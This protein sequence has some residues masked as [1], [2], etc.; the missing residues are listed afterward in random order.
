MLRAANRFVGALD[1]GQRTK[2]QFEFKDNERGNWHFIPK[3]RKGLP[4]KEMNSDQRK[5]ALALLASGLSSHGYEKATSIMNLETILH[6]L[7]GAARK[8]PRDPEL[9]YFSVFGKPGPKD[10][11]GWRV[12]GHHLS[13]NFTVVDGQLVAGTPSFMGVNPGEVRAG[14]RKGLRILAEEEDT[15]RE[16]LKSLSPELRKKAIFT[17]TAPKEIITEA[18][19]KVEPLEKEGLGADQLDAAQKQMLLHLIKIYVERLRPEMAD[20]DLQKIRKAGLD[21]VYFA[22]AGGTEKGEPHYY[23]VQGPTFLLE[24]DNTQNDAN[25]IHAVWRDFQGDFGEDLLRKHYEQ[26]HQ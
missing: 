3:S 24:Y 1:E 25:H 2:A 9:Y 6:D 7:E 11:W 8:L 16:L 22:W 18:K 10:T 20:E 26:D 4:I 15:G 23:R 19:R 21:K 13:A 17:E 14:P 5:L 12:E